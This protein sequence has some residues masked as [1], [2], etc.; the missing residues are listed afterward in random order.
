MESHHTCEP[1][2][3]LTLPSSSGKDTGFQQLR[4][5]LE[6]LFF[7]PVAE[8]SS[9]KRHETID[10]HSFTVKNKPRDKPW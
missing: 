9:D 8:T 3:L 4:D 7:S 5:C 2:S 6:G 10:W 1:Y